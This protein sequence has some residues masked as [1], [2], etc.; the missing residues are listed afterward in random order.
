MGSKA[1]CIILSSQ[2]KKGLLGSSAS[3]GSLIFNKSLGKCCSDYSTVN[4][5]LFFSAI[6]S[7]VSAIAG[8]IAAATLYGFFDL[9]FIVSN[10]GPA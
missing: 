1:R 10:K 3:K 9:K 6:Y 2:S 8:K 7:G 4:I 5:Y